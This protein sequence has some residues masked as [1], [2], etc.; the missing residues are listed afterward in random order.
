MGNAHDAEITEGYTILSLTIA[1][2][3]WPSKSLY[4]ITSFVKLSSFKAVTKAWFNDL[5]GINLITN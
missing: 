3:Q 5:D 2:S 4:G 1:F